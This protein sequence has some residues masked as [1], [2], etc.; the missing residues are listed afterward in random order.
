MVPGTKAGDRVAVL[1]PGIRGLSVCAAAKD[2]GAEFVMVTGAGERDHPRLAA[3]ERF[4]ADLVV[5]VTEE[6]PVAAFRRATGLGGA[7]VVVDVTANAP[8]A[9][10]QGVALTRGG[11]TFVVAGIRGQPVPTFEA[12]HLVYKELRIVGALGVDTQAYRAALDLLATQRYPFAEL[13]RE[14]VPLDGVDGLLQTMAGERDTPPVH[15]VVRP[16]PPVS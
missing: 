1:G 8:S 12:D 14:E 7:H 16:T 11:G 3:A 15:G 2:A 10:A 6:D 5:D 13:S 4:G 9:F